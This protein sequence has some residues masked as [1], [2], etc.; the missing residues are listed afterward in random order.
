LYRR[1][2]FIGNSSLGNIVGGMAEG[3]GTHTAEQDMER[4][5]RPPWWKRSW[6][7]TEFGQKSRWKWLMY[8][9]LL[10]HTVLLTIINNRL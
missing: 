1:R 6:E 5:K 7:W 8:R 4:D 3:K 10:V 9:V 2:A